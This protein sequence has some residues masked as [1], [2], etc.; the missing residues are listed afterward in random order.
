MTDVPI[1]S[2]TELFPRF[3]NK[4]PLA[5][6]ITCSLSFLI[7]LPFTCPVRAIHRFSLRSIIVLL[8]IQG[9]IYLFELLNEYAA[10]VSMVVVGFFEVYTVAYIY[11]LLCEENISHVPSSDLGRIQSIHERCEDDVGQTCSAVLSLCHVVYH[12]T[13]PD[14]REY[15]EREREKER[16]EC[17]C[18]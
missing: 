6:L 15:R 13:C 7:S 16:D 4:R 14:A 3:R 5:V 2:I 11:G 8:L 18:R 10:N 12:L 17:S 9:G 1:T